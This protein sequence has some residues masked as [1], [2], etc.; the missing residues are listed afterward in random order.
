VAGPVEVR[1]RRF[2]G[3][4]A[5]VAARPAW[6]MTDECKPSGPLVQ[7]RGQAPSDERDQHV[8]L[9]PELEQVYDHEREAGSGR[10]YVRPSSC[11]GWRLSLR[12]RRGCWGASGRW[13]WVEGC[14]PPCS[15]PLVSAWRLEPVGWTRKTCPGE[16]TS[17]GTRRRPAGTCRSRYF[18]E[19]LPGL[20]RPV[21]PGSRWVL[22]GAKPSRL[23]E[24]RPMHAHRARACFDWLCCEALACQSGVLAVED[25]HILC[26][27]SLLARRSANE[28]AYAPAE[29]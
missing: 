20:S 3:V 5:R 27:A 13:G 16:P 17:S 2:I 19:Q 14:L 21:C 6:A 24:Y 22:G 25:R 8:D 23:R 10:S 1:P 26:A 12:S 15:M 7:Q 4:A 9:Y 29:S 18:P 28:D 11:G